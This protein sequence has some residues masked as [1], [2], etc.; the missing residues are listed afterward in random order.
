[1][2]FYDSGII[3]TYDA[4]AEITGVA[5]APNGDVWEGTRDGLA[6]F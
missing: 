2:I 6:R 1:L 5:A 3:K 4:G